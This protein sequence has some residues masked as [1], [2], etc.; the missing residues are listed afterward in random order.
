VSGWLPALGRIRGAL[1]GGICGDE[2]GRPA[3]ALDYRTLE[4][5]LGRI[6]GPLEESSRLRTVGTDDSALKHMLCEAI[7]RSGARDVTP[8]D[9]ADVWRMRMDPRQFYV[10]VQNAY[11][12]LTAESVAPEDCGIGNAGNPAAAYREAVSVA[13][14]VHRGVPLHAAGLVAAAVAEALSDDATV[15]SVLDRIVSHGASGGELDRSIAAGLALAR[16]SVSYDDFRARFYEQL[17]RFWPQHDPERSTAVDPRE[18]L[19]IAFGVFLVCSGD[20][21]ETI[22]GC[23][24]FGRDADTAA[25][26]AG[27]VAGALA[28]VE[29]LPVDWV[30]FV[31]ARTPVDQDELATQLLEVLRLRATRAAAASI[32]VVGGEKGG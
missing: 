26:I 25:T 11:F 12:K 1:L 18:T 7:V 17:L 20:P 9:W 27:A 21:K 22:L 32:P 13:R 29:A 3:E 28:G 5:R 16:S 10:P 31:R 8:A 14:L 6:T 4:R 2:I 15:E 19:P 30:E 23:A 24:N